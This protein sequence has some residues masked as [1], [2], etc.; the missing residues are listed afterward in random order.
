[1]QS[2]GGLI[3]DDNQYMRKIVRD[4]LMNIGVQE[5]HE[6]G[7]ASPGSK[8]SACSRPIS[9]SSTG[10]C[11]C[12]TERSGAHR[13]LA[14]R[15]SGARRADHH[16]QRPR[17]A[18]ARSRSRRGSASTNSSQAG[19]RA[20]AARPHRWRSSPSRA[21]MVQ[22]GD[23]YGPEPRK[24]F[25]SRCTTPSMA[26][27]PTA[28]AEIIAAYPS[29]SLLCIAY[30]HPPTFADWVVSNSPRGPKLRRARWCDIE[31]VSKFRA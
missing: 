8:R 7:T 11:R 10:K 25:A 19:V 27:L 21:R 12:S 17:R 30:R 20:D 29:D 31:G 9:S 5:V 24:L 4:L 3:V 23:Y 22:V 2:I 28:G 14:R 26:R 6:A 13:A 18:L 15:V 16:A 1:M